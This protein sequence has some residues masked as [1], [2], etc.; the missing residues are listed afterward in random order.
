MVSFGCVGQV[1]AYG[2]LRH[3]DHVGRVD[4]GLG[5]DEPILDSWK[6]STMSISIIPGFCLPFVTG[7]EPTTH[8]QRELAVFG[9]IRG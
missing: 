9:W 7:L 5:C 1:G 3:M 4:H 2:R 6:R 8:L